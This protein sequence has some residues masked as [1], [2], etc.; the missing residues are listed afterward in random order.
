MSSGN[1]TATAASIAAPYLLTLLNTDAV[2]VIDAACALSAAT[3]ID[4]AATALSSSPPASASSAAINAV[5][6][7]GKVLLNNLELAAQALLEK[8]AAT[9]GGLLVGESVAVAVGG[10]YAELARL[11]P[12]TASNYAPCATAVTACRSL[13]LDGVLVP[14]EALAD[15]RDSGTLDVSLFVRSISP[16]TGENRTNET[17]LQLV[18]ILLTLPGGN[19]LPVSNLTQPVEIYFPSP[20]SA[21]KQRKCMTWISGDA[22]SYDGGSYSEAGMVTKVSADGSITCLSNHL[23]IFGMM[24]CACYCGSCH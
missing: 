9:D 7:A 16:W 15:A 8:W 3:V 14:S 12:A 24:V 22:N 11:N 23:S 13:G 21:G 6:S 18:V 4:G 10:S 1:L 17:V 19:L 20:A 2:T 5:A